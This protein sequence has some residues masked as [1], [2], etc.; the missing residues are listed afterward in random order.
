MNKI[1]FRVKKLATIE[2]ND[3]KIETFKMDHSI[4]ATNCFSRIANIEFHFMWMLSCKGVKVQ[5]HLNI[6]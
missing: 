2:R 6:E 3:S 1:I 5:M 4:L